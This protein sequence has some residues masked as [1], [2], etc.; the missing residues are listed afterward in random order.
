MKPTLL[1]SSSSLEGI[2]KVASE[3][4]C[5]SSVELVEEGDHY[6]V[7]TGRG[8]TGTIVAAGRRGRWRF[9][10]RDREKG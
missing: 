3:F 10:A 6:R 4:F 2:R 9:E 7:H 8:S 1:G 5:G